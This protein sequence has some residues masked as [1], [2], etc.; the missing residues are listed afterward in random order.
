MV[1]KIEPG[2]RAYQ[3]MRSLNKPLS[4]NAIMAQI[5]TKIKPEI[6]P[7]LQRR[8]TPAVSG[9]STGKKIP[10]ALLIGGF[11]AVALSLDRGLLSKAILF[12]MVR[13]FTN[14]GKK[15]NK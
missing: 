8:G 4:R 9:K 2:L 7:E 12:S 1:K 10:R 3:K 15:R 6:T 11:I 14:I 5:N 13:K